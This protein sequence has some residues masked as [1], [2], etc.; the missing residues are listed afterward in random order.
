MYIKKDM[1]LRTKS[2]N[3]LASQTLHVP[4]LHTTLKL[5]LTPTISLMKQ[6]TF[7]TLRNKLA[8]DVSNNA[9]RSE[10]IALISQQLHDDVYIMP[11]SES[12]G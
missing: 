10:L 11:Q 12:D 5:I 6:A 7:E 2:K 1:Q 4:L 9:C 3:Y 8:E